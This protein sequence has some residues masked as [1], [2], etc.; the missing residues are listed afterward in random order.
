M[1]LPQVASIAAAYMPET[2]PESESTESTGGLDLAHLLPSRIELRS[3]LAKVALQERTKETDESNLRFSNTNS[4]STPIEIWGDV[5]NG[6]RFER[7]PNG[8]AEYEFRSGETLRAVVTDLLTECQKNGSGMGL[9][10]ESVRSAMSAIMIYNNISD[11]DFVPTGSKL[12]IPASIVP[13][14]KRVN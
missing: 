1:T 12:V 13:G 4:A 5:R 7:T 3:F 14:K 11:P 9:D 6:R 2:R 10:Y 8:C